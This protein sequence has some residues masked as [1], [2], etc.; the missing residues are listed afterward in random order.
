MPLPHHIRVILVRHRVS[1]TD[2]R[3]QGIEHAQVHRMHARLEKNDIRVGYHLIAVSDLCASQS[4][5]I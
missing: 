3:E 4:Q 2:L 5:T 1:Q